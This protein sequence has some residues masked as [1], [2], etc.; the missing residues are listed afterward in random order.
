MPSKAQRCRSSARV[1]TAQFAQPE[2]AAAYEEALRAAGGRT[3]E[4]VLR[5]MGDGDDAALEVGEF[6]VRGGMRLLV[7]GFDRAKLVRRASPGARSE[8]LA[9]N[10]QHTA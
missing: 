8:W 9:P 7:L 5:E 10:Y 1:G 2:L 6:E 3:L 4:A